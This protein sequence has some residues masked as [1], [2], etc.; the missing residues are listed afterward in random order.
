M[1]K[2]KDIAEAYAHGETHGEAGHIFIDGNIIYSYGKHFPIA[3]KLDDGIIL[4]NSDGYSNTTARHKSLVLNALQGRNIIFKNT[5][6]LKDTIEKGIKSLNE[7]AL[8]ELEK[9]LSL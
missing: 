3:V 7:L 9:P 5:E 2:N 1:V 6:Q 8:I 4:F